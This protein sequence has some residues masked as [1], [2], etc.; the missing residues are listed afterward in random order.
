MPDRAL[1][2]L[3]STSTLGAATRKFSIGT[4]L[5]P[6][7][8]TRASSLCLSSKASASAT[9]AGLAYA[10][11]GAF[12]SS[13]RCRIMQH[14]FR[15]GLHG[16]RRNP[17]APRLL[18]K[19]NAEAGRALQEAEGLRWRAARLEDA[20]LRAH[21]LQR[22]RLPAS[23]GRARRQAVAG[24][25]QGGE[26]GGDQDLRGLQPRVLPREARQGSDAAQPR[27]QR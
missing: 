7:A 23:Q 17:A 18:E 8:S 14:S 25:T 13:P 22:D 2:R 20:R 12:I 21:P 19:R 16:I 4:R 24:G 9:L 5:W 1:M 15:G 11:R 3:M 27:H 6:P 26:D 10:K